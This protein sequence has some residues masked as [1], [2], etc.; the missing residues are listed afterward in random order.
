MLKHPPRSGMDFLHI[1]NL[2]WSLHSYRSIRKTSSTIPIYKMG[3]PLDSPVSFRPISLTSCVLK[4]FERIILLCLLFFLESNSIFSPSQADFCPGQSTI[5]QIL[6]PSQS[7]LDEFNKPR[8][9]SQTI[10]S[11]IDF[12]KTFDSVWHPILFHKRI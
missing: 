1:F 4:L 10:F 12:S 5:G 7:I 11:T 6:F 9:G 3:K 8:P 2:S